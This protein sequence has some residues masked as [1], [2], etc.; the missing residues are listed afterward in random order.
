MYRLLVYSHMKWQYRPR[1][2]INEFQPFV[3]MRLQH[4]NR[5]ERNDSDSCSRNY[6]VKFSSAPKVLAL[7]MREKLTSPSQDSGYHT[8]K[9]EDLHCVRV[10]SEFRTG[11]DTVRAQLLRNF[12][13]PPYQGVH[14][15]RRTWPWYRSK[16]D[17][18]SHLVWCQ[19]SL[20]ND[21]MMTFREESGNR[22]GPNSLHL[23]IWL[24]QIRLNLIRSPLVRL[25]MIVYVGLQYVF[26]QAL[27]TWGGLP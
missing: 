15:T 27:D 4:L 6:L 17:K 3:L 24:S 2:L 14:P 12:A 19:A 7:I 21:Q 11:C 16:F 5:L 10:T 1:T 22:L 23:I 25:N 8:G 9:N 18:F 20:T 13:H 26:L